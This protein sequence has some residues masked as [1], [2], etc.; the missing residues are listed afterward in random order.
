MSLSAADHAEALAQR[1]RAGE[2][3]ALLQRAAAT[4]D[5]EASFRM[6]L[7]KLAGQYVA[8][9]LAG[10]R[11]A[12]ARAAAAGHADAASVNV[13][14]VAQG[15]GG[16]AEWARAVAL[17]RDMAG[18][19]PAARDQLAI[20]TAMALEADGAPR[21]LPAAEPL[22]VSPQVVRFTGLFSP[23]ECAFLVRCAEPWFQP[24]V[25]VDPR[26]G[27][28]VRDPVRSSDTAPFA[29][30]DV[31]PAMHALNR[32]IA[33]ASGT[34][35]TQGEPLQILSYRPGQQY[36]PHHDAIAGADNQRML[37]ALVYLNEDYR[38]GE[39]RFL[40]GGLTVKGATGDAI[41]FRNADAAGR[42]DPAARHAGLPVVGGRKLLASRWIRQR[43]LD[44]GDR[45]GL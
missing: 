11:A 28:Q 9:D 33:A 27:R 18:G 37:T 20:I 19:D 24:A 34:A 7:W 4:G 17:L 26:T 5:P 6:A 36:R 40:T 12:F 1:G 31:N 45:G 14:F 38:G 41:I 16:P 23:A 43:P 25:V 32:R 29:L 22:S 21:D 8:R 30:A 39:T 3:M 13:A 44:L 15:V 35:V 10:A 2:A 42:A